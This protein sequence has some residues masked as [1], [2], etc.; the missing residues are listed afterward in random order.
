M[1]P[2][3]IVS[4]DLSVPR[5]L[6]NRAGDQPGVV[7]RR[8]GRQTQTDRHRLQMA[9]GVLR[10]KIAAIEYKVNLPGDSE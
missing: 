4:R 10:K 6:T 2:E 9:G 8:C 5:D 3:G 1:I 7:E